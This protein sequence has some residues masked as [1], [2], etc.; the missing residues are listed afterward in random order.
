LY[1][2]AS[3]GVGLAVSL[4]IM[5]GGIVTSRGINNDDEMPWGSRPTPGLLRDP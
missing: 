1:T 5:I 2:D 4:T 3:C